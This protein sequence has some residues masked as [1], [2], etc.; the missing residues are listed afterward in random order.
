MDISSELAS[1][2]VKA[3]LISQYDKKTDTEQKQLSKAIESSDHDKVTELKEA[4][5]NAKEKYSIANWIADAATRMAK[6]LNF[7]THISK[8]VHPDA[9]GDNVSFDTVD[10]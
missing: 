5:V 4:L 7:G 8:G 6:Q 9:K 3:F 1:G 2:A 10:N